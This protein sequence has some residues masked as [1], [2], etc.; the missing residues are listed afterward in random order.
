[1]RERDNHLNTNKQFMMGNGVM[2]FAVIFVVVLFI[3]MAMRMQAV[4]QDGER[5]YPETYDIVLDRGF[6]GE[7]VTIYAND[8]ILWEGTIQDEQKNI[9][10]GRFENT[11]SL[12]IVDGETEKVSVIELS[13]KGGTYHLAK[14]QGE[15]TQVD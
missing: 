6:K 4:K 2:A 10:F 9:H 14:D 13:E 12:M 3:Y 5:Y 7:N 8:S 15:V 11:T 1:M